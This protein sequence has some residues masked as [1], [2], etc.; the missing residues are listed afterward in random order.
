VDRVRAVASVYA[1][2]CI[3]NLAFSLFEFSLS[4]D[5]SSLLGTAVVPVPRVVPH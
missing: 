4:A 3:A 5:A 1:S 2:P